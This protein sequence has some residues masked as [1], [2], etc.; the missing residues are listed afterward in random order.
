MEKTLP[1]PCALS[2]ARSWLMAG[3]P[4]AAR[5]FDPAVAVKTLYQLIE[6]LPAVI[7]MYCY[8]TPEN[9]R[10]VQE[11]DAKEE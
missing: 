2:Y 7:P 8:G 5:D 3:A 10:A 11:C 4:A 1:T 9:R 6:A